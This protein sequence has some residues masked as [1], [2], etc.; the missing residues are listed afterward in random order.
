MVQYWS[1][2][3]KELA[4]SS[5]F[6]G[7]GCKLLPSCPPC[8]LSLFFI[9]L[10]GHKWLENDQNMVEAQKVLKN[11]QKHPKKTKKRKPFPPADTSFLLPCTI[12][13]WGPNLIQIYND[14]CRD[15]MGAKHSICL[16]RPTRVLV[17]NM[18]FRGTYLGQAGTG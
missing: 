12:L 18:G 7:S 15:L 14:S 17:R 1:K 16:K 9:H 10:A 11:P 6:V 13:L 3:I 8:S 5:Q 2:P 4:R